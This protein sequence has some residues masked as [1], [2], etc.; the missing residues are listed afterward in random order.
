MFPR[1]LRS[2]PGVQRRAGYGQR[3]LELPVEE[4]WNSVDLVRGRCP[5]GP[6]YRA[7]GHPRANSQPLVQVKEFMES[8]GTGSGKKK[9]KRNSVGSVSSLSSV[10]SR[11]NIKP[12]R[13]KPRVDSTSNL[14]HVP[15]GGKVLK[16]P[17]P[18]FRIFRTTPQE[19]VLC[20]CAGQ[21][22]GA[23]KCLLFIYFV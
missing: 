10:D 11:G 23:A 21:P 7:L 14:N 9:L 19:P 17:E 4:Q 12:K 20:G 16:H 2:S 22:L 5:E 15:R 13:I 3:F 8:R 6:R 1:R 18:C